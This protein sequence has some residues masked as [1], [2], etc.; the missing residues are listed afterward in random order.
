MDFPFYLRQPTSGSLLANQIH[1]PLAEIAL[2]SNF[3]PVIILLIFSIIVYILFRKYKSLWRKTNLLKRELRGKDETLTSV[4]IDKQRLMLEKDQLLKKVHHRVKNNLQ[5]M[6]S[7]LHTQA[8]YLKDPAAKKAID[9][10]QNRMQ[11]M[12]V[13]QKKMYESEDVAEVNMTDFLEE[14]LKYLL[15]SLESD[16]MTTEI[17]GDNLQLDVTQAGFVGLIVNETIMN[18]LKC[19]NSTAKGGRFTVCLS[20]L[21]GDQVHLMLSYFN[22]NVSLLK[23]IQFGINNAGLL[24]EVA[25]Q[26]NATLKVVDKINLEISLSFT[27]PLTL[28]DTVN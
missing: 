21:D 12:I 23:K 6:L 18:I 10:S 19:I 2:I 3:L 27:K 26:L 28:N 11:A 13:I 14:L 20:Q 24:R 5:V 25:H 1:K 9:E 15:T 8:A 22:D 17:T 16:T 7:L 4:T